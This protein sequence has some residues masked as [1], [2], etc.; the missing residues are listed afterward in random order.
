MATE[1]VRLRL[2]NYDAREKMLS[3]LG[4]NGYRVWVEE[5]K[6]SVFGSKFYICFETSSNNKEDD[7]E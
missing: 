3:A 6:K 5:K 4:Q 1:V 2:D 7:D